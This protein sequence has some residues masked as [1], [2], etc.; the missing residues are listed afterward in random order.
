MS[1]T[2]PVLLDGVVKGNLTVTKDGLVTVFS[3]RCEDPGHLVRLSVY[4]GGREGYLGV[5]SPE[6]GALCLHRKMSRTAM[7][8]FPPVV[9]YA[10]EAG[11]A[12]PSQ[13]PPPERACPPTRPGCATIPNISGRRCV[14]RRTEPEEAGLLWYPTGDGKLYTVWQGHAYQAVPLAPHGQ[15]L[16]GLVEKRTVQGVEYAVYELVDG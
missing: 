14:P 2:Y 5:M 3:A 8:D 13:E 16:Q 1:E 10:A 4:G 12:L 6:K 7:A 11:R 9:E 15:P